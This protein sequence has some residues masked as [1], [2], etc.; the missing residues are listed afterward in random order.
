MKMPGIDICDFI[1]YPQRNFKFRKSQP[2]SSSLGFAI[3][4]GLTYIVS[5]S[6]RRFKAS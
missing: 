3:T 5:H 4:F 2:S 1:S 6:I